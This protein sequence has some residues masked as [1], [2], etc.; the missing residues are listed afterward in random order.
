MSSNPSP[1][2][3]AAWTS[4]H[5]TAGDQASHTAGWKSSPSERP[6]HH[7]PVAKSRP[8]S[9]ASLAATT[10]TLTRSV[11]LLLARLGSFTPAAAVTVAVLVTR[12]LA[13]ERIVACTV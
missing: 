2:K 8:T 12:P 13:D 11:A 6:T 9:E 10:T 1:L 3:S 7:C 5:V 4:A